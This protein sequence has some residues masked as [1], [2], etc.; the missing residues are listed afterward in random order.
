[1]ILD[2]RRLRRRVPVDDDGLDI[3]NLT[4][5]SGDIGGEYAGDEGE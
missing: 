3:A 4:G 2:G 5:S 1:M